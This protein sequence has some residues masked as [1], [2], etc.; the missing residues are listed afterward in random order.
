[1]TDHEVKLYTFANIDPLVEDIRKSAMH[2][3]RVP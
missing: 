1:M 3:S 2:H